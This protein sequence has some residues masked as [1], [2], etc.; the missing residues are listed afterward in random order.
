VGRRQPR[1]P[2]TKPR[3]H[4]PG[5]P[6]ITTER[7]TTTTRLVPT[8]G[9][10]PTR[11]ETGPLPTIRPHFHAERSP[12][13]PGGA[14][15]T[16]DLNHLPRTP[17]T[18]PGGGR[19]PTSR[20]ARGSR[21]R[22]GLRCVPSKRI[23]RSHLT[24][25]W[26]G[27]LSS[28][29]SRSQLF[30]DPRFPSRNRLPLTF[31]LRRRVRAAVLRDAR[32]AWREVGGVAVRRTV[33]RNPAAAH[34]LVR[35]EKSWRRA[36]TA[37]LSH[38]SGVGARWLMQGRVPVVR[39]ALTVPGSTLACSSRR[40]AFRLARSDIAAELSAGLRGLARYERS[41]LH[42]A[43]MVLGNG[44]RADAGGGGRCS[45]SEERLGGGHEL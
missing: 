43:V 41:S 31:R 11:P 1:P 29:P 12:R 42:R 6:P 8:P 18:R 7:L 33:D 15:M 34:R 14:P 35:R 4:T 37:G 2:S 10:R 16:T 27:A 20:C 22:P 25:G 13:P 32:L 28:R 21:S 39:F 5:T 3:R 24:R 23:G 38:L 36:M 30:R 40:T 19:G 17:G 45:A 9:P 26:A 44:F